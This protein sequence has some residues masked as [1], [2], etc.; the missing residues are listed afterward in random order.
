[1]TTFSIL[2]WLW[3]N[4]VAFVAG[5]FLLLVA[6]VYWPSRKERF[7]QDAMIPLREDR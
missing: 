3:E 1:M 7:Q 2:H 6:S 5:V 4:S